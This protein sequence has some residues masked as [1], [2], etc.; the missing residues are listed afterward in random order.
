MT[1]REELERREDRDLAPYA[2]RSFRSR[3]RDHPVEPDELRT[4]FQRDRD[5]IIHC[6]AFRRL[7]YKTW[8][9]GNGGRSGSSRSW[10]GTTSPA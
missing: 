1:V 7:E 6:K 8:E 3:G 9:R 5:R 2:V 4:E 10:Y